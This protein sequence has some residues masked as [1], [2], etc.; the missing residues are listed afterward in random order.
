MKKNIVIGLLTVVSL[1][2][3]I[4]GCVQQTEA[5]RQEKLAIGN[6]IQGEQQSKEAAK[7][8]H[9]AEGVE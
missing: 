2:L 9:L 7:Q 5:K 3:L 4:Y 8:L 1:A 6:A